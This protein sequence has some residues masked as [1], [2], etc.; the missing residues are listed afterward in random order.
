ML[1]YCYIANGIAGIYIG[2]ALVSGAKKKLGLMPC[3]AISFILAAAGIFVLKLPGIVVMIVISSMVLGFLDGFGTPMCTDQFMELNV[4]KNA[5]DESTALIFSVV[6]SYILLTFSPMIAEAMLLPGDGLLSPMM[7]GTAV[8]ITAAVVVLIYGTAK[9][10]S[11]HSG[12][13]GK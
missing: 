8:Y 2:P 5:V 13:Q 7:I 4:V 11:S 1:S 10:K 9:K 12:K 3:I 6:I